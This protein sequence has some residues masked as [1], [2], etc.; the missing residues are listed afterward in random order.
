MASVNTQPT[1]DTRGPPVPRDL[2]H[3]ELKTDLEVQYWS[4]RLQASRQQLEDAVDK[5]GGSVSAVTDYLERNADRR[6]EPG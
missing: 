2:K 4:K 1:I 3:V 5:V 6:D